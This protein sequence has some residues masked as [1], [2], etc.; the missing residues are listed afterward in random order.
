MPADTRRSV[1]L[2]TVTGGSRVFKALAID[3]GDP[4][5]TRSP[6]R[7]TPAWTTAAE[8]RQSG[9]AAA[10]HTPLRTA[11]VA[12]RHAALADPELGQ[13]PGVGRTPSRSLRSCRMRARIDSASSSFPSRA[14]R[15]CMLRVDPPV[16]GRVGR[17]SRVTVPSWRRPPPSVPGLRCNLAGVGPEVGHLLVCSQILGQS[18]LGTVDHRPRIVGEVIQR[19]QVST[20]GLPAEMETKLLCAIVED[21][22]TGSMSGATTLCACHHALALALN[23][24]TVEESIAES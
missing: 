15:S 16:P 1:R 9:R 5:S 13:V 3:Q 14:Y 7:R 18:P 17:S 11:D 24:N 8:R 23:R 21:S 2:D 19:H 10:P 20:H 22:R 6:S 4:T 12:I